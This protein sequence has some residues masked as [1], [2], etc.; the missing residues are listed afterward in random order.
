MKKLFLFSIMLMFS[1]LC[2]PQKVDE[3]D[4]PDAVKSTFKVRFPFATDIKWEKEDTI[5]GSTFLMDKTTTEA[6]FSEKGSWIETEWEVP[7]EYTPKAIKGY[8]DTTYA[9][10]KILEL[11]I[12]DYPA[13][14]K[15]Y[16]TEVSKKKDCENLYFSLTG[17][18]KK[19]EKA[20]C[21]KKKKCCKKKDSYKT[22]Q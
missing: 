9:G 18:F 15:L 19:S 3:A 10:Y 11:E 8:M 12:M 22:K 21:E 20:V 16:K 2:F 1:A 17:E 14:G 4:V 13:D 5:Y 7:V 6:D